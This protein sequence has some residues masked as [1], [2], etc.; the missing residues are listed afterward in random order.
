MTGSITIEVDGAC[1]FN[2][3]PSARAAI[4]VY[5]GEGSK[6]NISKVLR[7]AAPTSQKAELS[8]GICA[9][10]QAFVITTTKIAGILNEVVIQTDSKY[11]FTGL[12]EWVFK[13]R[14]N[15]YM[16]AKGE[17]VTNTMMFQRLDELVHTLEKVGVRVKF[18]HVPRSFNQKADALAN[19]A[20]ANE[21]LDSKSSSLDPYPDAW[22]VSNIANYHMCNSRRPF[23][24][25]KVIHPL[26]VSCHGGKSGL[27][28]IGTGTITR[29]LILQNGA[30]QT[31]NLDNVLH[32]PG[33][34]LNLMSLSRP[35]LEM[36]YSS[37]IISKKGKEIGWAKI[38]GLYILQQADG[39]N[40]LY[41]Q[42]T[43]EED[44]PA[45]IVSAWVTANP[46]ILAP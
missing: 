27:H 25:Y 22:I 28:A 46:R 37:G 17:P 16:N 23:T 24:N 15:G 11:L 26:R 1:R 5:F 6:Y 10:E 2:G 42:G 38:D 31:V 34:L 20:L 8:A 9:L 7:D 41:P 19:E 44:K 12:T 3:T 33:L 29:T 40:T 45:L 13:W 14:A 21:A 35:G 4:G 43:A 32:V 18:A 39:H 36:N 30:C